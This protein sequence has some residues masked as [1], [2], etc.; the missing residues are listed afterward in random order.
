MYYNPAPH[1]SW[2]IV[3]EGTGIL[4]KPELRDAFC[5]MVS[6]GLTMARNAGRRPAKIKLVNTP[7][8]VSSWGS[9]VAGELLV[10]VGCCE[11]VLSLHW[12]GPYFSRGYHVPMCIL[13]STN[14]ISKGR[15]RRNRQ[16][17][18]R[19]GLQED[20]DVGSRR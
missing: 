15:R 9:S 10:I 14:W 19:E 2:N 5:K 18:V 7:L 17:N 6:S 13:E 11:R 1:G 3:G 16:E 12:C 20:M 4:H 8:K